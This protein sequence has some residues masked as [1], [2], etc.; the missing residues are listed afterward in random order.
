MGIDYYIILTLIKNLN[1]GDGASLPMI[2]HHFFRIIDNKGVS[3]S[4][5]DNNQLLVTIDALH[6]NG[7]IQMN[8]ISNFV[9]TQEGMRWLKEHPFKN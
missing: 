7:L 9:I 3:S 4:I 6:N 1:E 2:D 8:S 5:T